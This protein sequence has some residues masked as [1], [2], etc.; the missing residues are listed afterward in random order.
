V[1]ERVFDFV[2]LGEKNP[3]FAGG[4]DVRD[5]GGFQVGLT[6]PIHFVQ[7]DGNLGNYHWLPVINHRLFQHAFLRLRLK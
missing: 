1:I 2:H 7:L 3:V 4:E 6:L 5:S